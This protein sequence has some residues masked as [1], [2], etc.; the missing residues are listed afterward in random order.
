MI[1]IA[2]FM[3]ASKA[4]CRRARIHYSQF[5]LSA[6]RVGG[7]SRLQEVGTGEAEIQSAGRWSSEALH[8]YV[9]RSTSKGHKRA[10]L[11]LGN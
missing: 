10:A 11:M 8:T 2:T 9:R 6:F 3:R 5:R 1:T 7:A 4:A